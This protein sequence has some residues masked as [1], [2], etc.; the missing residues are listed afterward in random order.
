MSL[1]E[2]VA[3]FSGLKTILDTLK[4]FKDINDANVRNSIAIDLQGKVLAAYQ[5]QLALADKVAGLEG[6]V[7]RLQ[8]W[9]AEKAKYILKDVGQGCLAYVLKDS[10]SGIDTPHYLCAN[11]YNKGDKSILQNHKHY[12]MRAVTLDCH[13]CRS[14]LVISASLGPDV[15]PWL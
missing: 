1:V 12:A 7:A 9:S 6:E 8:D 3:G 13:R 2:V 4:G 10:E 5:D 11:C 14:F 15:K